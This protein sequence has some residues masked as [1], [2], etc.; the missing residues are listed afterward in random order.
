MTPNVCARSSNAFARPRPYG[1]A[2]V[3]H[4]DALVAPL[5]RVLGHLLADGV[6]GEGAAE[7]V[8][9]SLRREGRVGAHRGEEQQAVLVVDGR[10]RDRDVRLEVPDDGHHARAVGQAL[11]DEA[12]LVDALVVVDPQHAQSSAVHAACA[13]HLVDCEVD[14][15]PVPKIR[16][17]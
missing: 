3:V 10:G 16:A 1:V 8:A 15:L 7:H 17:F 4:A 12:A 11:G 6:L 14:A 13:V 5:R 9:E 2:N